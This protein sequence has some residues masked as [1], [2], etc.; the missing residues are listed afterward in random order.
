MAILG[1]QESRQQDH[2]EK[3]RIQAKGTP[4]PGPPKRKGWEKA[5]RKGGAKK[6]NKP[7]EKG[8]DRF[9]NV[10]DARPGNAPSTH[11]S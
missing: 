4:M 2:I 9:K 7:Y 1:I 3:D 8:K 5:K 6:K 11:L 10:L